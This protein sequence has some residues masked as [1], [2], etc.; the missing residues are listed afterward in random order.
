MA[1]WATLDYEAFANLIWSNGRWLH[2]LFSWGV[3]DPQ[4]ERDNKKKYVYILDCL[5]D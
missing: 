5:L 2:T 1:R 4:I 3:K